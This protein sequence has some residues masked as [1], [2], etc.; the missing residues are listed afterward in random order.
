[1]YANLSKAMSSIEV[2]K[3]AEDGSIERTSFY[4]LLLGRIQREFE[5]HG[6]DMDIVSIEYAINQATSVRFLGMMCNN[7][8]TIS[9]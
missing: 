4:K 5:R 8:Q 2:D 1:M 9:L 6:N 7:V 3:E